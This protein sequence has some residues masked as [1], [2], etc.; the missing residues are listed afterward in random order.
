MNQYSSVI[1]ASKE[2]P[3]RIPP[4]I[5]LAVVLKKIFRKVI[6]VTSGC[7]DRVR[8]K[9]AE[10]NIEL[11]VFKGHK[12][13]GL[14][15]KSLTWRSFRS[16]TLNVLNEAGPHALLW[17]S[18]GDAA[19][20]L[21]RGISRYPF[22]LQLHELYDE[23]PAYRLLLG[24]PARR[25]K[26]VVVPEHSRAAIVRKWYDLALTPYVLP[27]KPYDHPRQRKIPVTDVCASREFEELGNDTK[28]VLYQGH[29][30]RIRDVRPI[31]AAVNRMGGEWRF[32]VMGPNPL[33]FVDAIREVC[34]G[35]VYIP[36]VPAPFHLEITSHAHI[37]VT[38]YDYS[39]LN[40]IFCAPNKIWEYAG[41]GIPMLCSDLPGLRFTVQTSGAG[42]CSGLVHLE[43]IV[44][45]LQLIDKKYESY[46]MSSRQF[47]DSVDLEHKIQ[48]IIHNIM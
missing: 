33:G 22:V 14:V 6:I 5:T 24:Y 16:A 9:L 26:S 10:S 40:N 39:C 11:I 20:A 31:A 42:V 29:I 48:D 35:L 46:S 15:G 27:N 38:V 45:C 43:E 4:V 34:P 32:V 44:E 3:A 23:H 19:L 30:S 28:I 1:I 18:G 13:N 47:F 2:S 21:G 7:D 36:F 8:D 25:A 12:S 17:I 41:F 37:G